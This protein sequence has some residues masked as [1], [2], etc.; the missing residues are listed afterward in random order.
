MVACYTPVGLAGDGSIGDGHI[1]DGPRAIDAATGPNCSGVLDLCVMDFGSGSGLTI[2]G[3]V[4]HRRRPEVWLGLRAPVYT[5]DCV[6]VA[7]S[8][9][10]QSVSVTGSRP[11]ALLA[12]TIV[13]TGMLDASSFSAQVGAGVGATNAACSYGTTLVPIASGG[14]GGGFGTAGGSGLGPGGVANAGNPVPLA[15]LGLRAGCA[16]LAGT[17]NEDSTGGA[18]GI[19]GGA[20]L[21]LG[22]TSINVTAGTEILADGAGGGGGPGG[23]PYGGGGGGGTGGLIVLETP[24]LMVDDTAQICALGGGGGGGGDS[25]GNG[26][27]LGGVGSLCSA[28]GGGPSNG[29]GGDGGMGAPGSGPGANGMVGAAGGAGGGGGGGNGIILLGNGASAASATLATI[30]PAPRDE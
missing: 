17:S 3:S 22:D 2:H 12:N 9:T 7:P 16:G 19:P 11:I 20:I 25:E 13:V 4:R 10:I 21:L 8:I 30:S 18:A 27:S 14:E 1:G 15:G 26:F 24:T 29:E 6:V 5:D 28:G 23:T